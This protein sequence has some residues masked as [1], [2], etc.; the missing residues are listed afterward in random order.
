MPTLMRKW[1]AMANGGQHDINH[2]RAVSG[3][4]DVAAVANRC[5]RSCRHQGRLCAS[6]RGVLRPGDMVGDI[7]YRDAKQVSGDIWRRGR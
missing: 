6:S 2:L 4:D 3:I 1:R 5:F 7:N